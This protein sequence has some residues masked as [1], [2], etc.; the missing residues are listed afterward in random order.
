MLL[1]QPM[2]RCVQ[3]LLS[4]DCDSL[5]TPAI[6]LKHG[7]LLGIVIITGFD[8]LPFFF[9]IIRVN[10]SLRLFAVMQTCDSLLDIVSIIMSDSLNA[11]AII[12]SMTRYNNVLLF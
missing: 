1:S 4:I 10:D 12:T 7:S 5:N 3:M 6:I 8:S 11:L 9:A 2:T